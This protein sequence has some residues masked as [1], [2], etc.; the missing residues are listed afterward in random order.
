MTEQFLIPRRQFVIAALGPAAG[1]F[2]QLGSANAQPSDHTSRRI[3]A[4]ASGSH[5]TFGPLKQIDAGELSVGYADLGPT[6]GMP[7]LLLHGWPYDIHSFGDVAS[8]LAAVGY[9]VLVP[10]LRGYGTTRFCRMPSLEMANRRL[11]R[12]MLSTSLTR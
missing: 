8:A 4:V 7:V 2:A 9:R 1:T 10:Y 6:S 12:W 3:P 5:T 11:F